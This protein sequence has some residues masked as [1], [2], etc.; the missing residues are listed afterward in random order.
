MA[1]KSSSRRP[2]GSAFKQQRLKSCQPVIAPKSVIPVFYLIAII[3][4]PLGGYLLH[5]S[6]KVSELM[7]DYTHCAQTE[8]NGG[9][10]TG[11]FKN[12]PINNAVIA[13]YKPQIS[14]N[15][16]RWKQR[17][18]LAWNETITQC[19][20][21][22]TVPT[23]LNPPV[24]FLYRLTNFYQ[25]ERSY[26]K[27]LDP[28]QLSGGKP[29]RAQLAHNCKDLWETADHKIIY[30]CG[31][32][33]NSMFNDTFSNLTLVNSPI[34]NI[35]TSYNFSQTGI[36]ASDDDDKYDET[37]YNISEIAPPPNWVK[38]YPDGKYTPE[39]P[40]I[41]P[42]KNELFQVWM[43]LAGLPRFRK[44]YGI[45]NNNT[46]PIGT[47]EL[48]IDLLWPVSSG[49]KSFVI[50]TTTEIGGKNPFL[51]LAYIII[52]MLGGVL[53]I[54]FTVKHFLQTP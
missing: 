1:E 4:A 8:S 11:E 40:P 29:D 22:F 32:I 54:V 26:V 31:M 34:Q 25:N 28:D 3:F 12:M 37:S 21:Q 45:N 39:F 50:T 17:Q 15:F 18:A 38:R 20:I 41:D 10:P 6:D 16:P 30:P 46:L 48:V 42:S 13:F 51:G 33:A 7:I 9:A 52:G 5:E 47:Y 24:H 35:P 14:Y 23:E 43:R 49:R 53:G 44:L 36:A 27:S 2:G 19:V